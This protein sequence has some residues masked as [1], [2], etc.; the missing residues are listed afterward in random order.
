MTVDGLE[1]HG[2][3]SFLKAGIAFA[4][5]V[6]TVSENYAREITTQEHGCGLDGLLRVRKDRGEL[7]GILNGIDGSWEMLRAEATEDGFLANWKT[8]KTEEVRRMFGLDES[9]GPLFSI[10]SRLV[11]QKGVDLSVRAAELIVANGGQLVITG[12]GDPDLENAVKA[13]AERHPGSVAAYVGFDDERAR[14][15]YGGSD[16][17]LMP[18][19]FEPCG[20]GQM[21]AQSQ[22]ALPVACRTGGLA[23]TID[24]GHTGFLFARAES[25]ALQRAVGR[26]FRAFWSGPVMD[27]MRRKAIAKS[28]DWSGSARQYTSLYTAA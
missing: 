3:I 27:T 20:L 2:Q 22:A 7:T 1:F 23:D 18:S 25:F 19:R 13:L 8:R 5:H 9:E 21:Y 17:L 10:I 24:D 26:A 16:F 28:F 6:T 15:M 14:V 11:H 12:E 4:S